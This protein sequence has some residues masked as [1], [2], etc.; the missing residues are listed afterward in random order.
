M[1]MMLLAA[2][3]ADL[4]AAVSKA[5]EMTRADRPCRADADSDEIV[6]CARRDADRYRVPFVLS[7]NPAN[8]VPAQTAELLEERGR[9]PCG[10][11]AF[12]A[13]CGGMVGVSVTVGANG[14]RYV[15]RELAP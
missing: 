12:T 1:S 6:V 9:L 10:Q 14:V 15:R 5:R 4:A 11:G 7:A 8:S 13:Q 3:D 2:Q